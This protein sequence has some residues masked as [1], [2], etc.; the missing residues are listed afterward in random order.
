M[1]GITTWK[2]RLASE[3]GQTMVEY[4]LILALIAAVVIGAIYVLG[5]HIA[6]LFGSI[7]NTVAQ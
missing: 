3:K 1:V 5:G 4:G 2:S 6:S 7:S